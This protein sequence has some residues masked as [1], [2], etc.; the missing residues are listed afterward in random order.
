MRPISP[1]EMRAIDSNCT[2]FGLIPLQLMENAGSALASEA[3]KRARGNRIAVVAGRGN[4]GGDAFV[5]ARHLAEFDVTVFLL[6]RSRDIATEEARRN[7]EILDRLGFDLREV[8]DSR[9]LEELSKYD[10]ILDAIFGTGVRGAV[11][12]LEAEAIDAINSAR[13]QVISVDVPSGIGTEKVIEPEVT[14]TFHRP[15]EGIPGE[16]VVAG[17]GIPPSAEF[18]AGPGDLALVASRAPASHKGQNGRVLVIG[19]GPYSGAPALSAMAALRAGADLV[20][21]AV[22]E[23]VSDVIAGFSPN[24]IVRPLS[25]DHLS[26]DDLPALRELIP[27]HDVVVV[28][29]GLGRHPETTE[30]LTKIV[31]ECGKMVMDAD[32]LLPGVP[33][34]GI[35]T[36]HESEFRRVS[37]I[38]VPPGRVQN[39]TLM[40]FA[41]DMGLTILLKGK[42]DLITDGTVIRG[43]ATGNAGMTVGGTGDVLAGITGAFYANAPPLRAA[44]A[45]AF[46]NGTAGDLAFE[47]KGYSLLATDVI[48]NIPLA[49]W[50]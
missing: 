37:S 10:L 27:R 45:A 32:A 22:P 6:G 47:E 35:I 30:A 3:R 31:P 12:G 17:I 43:N 33:L 5:A 18:L 19:G 23:N 9:E 46:V 1:E 44:V 41:R 29:M 14:V 36:P 39:E 15:K 34:K 49:M 26:S 25:D 8:R 24:L 48:E 4:N 13:K 28:G 50:Q 20:T 2:Y 7:W 40:T 42:V 21:V 16:V 38:G 11:R